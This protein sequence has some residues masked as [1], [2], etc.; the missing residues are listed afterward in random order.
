MDAGD[1][2]VVAGLVGGEAPGE[3]DPRLRNVAS[4]FRLSA[5]SRLAR[6]L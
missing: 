3:A 6:N 1:D 2:V 4:S 5:A